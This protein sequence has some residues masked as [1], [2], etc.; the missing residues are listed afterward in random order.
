MRICRGR[1]VSLALGT[2][3]LFALVTPARFAQAAATVT[4]A[5][6]G[7]A[8]SADTVGGVF[9]S[10]TGPV[11]SEGTTADIGTG[12]IILNAP[13]GFEFD[14]AVPAVTV[15]VTRIGGTGNNNRNINNVASGTGLPVT[16]I[17]ASQIT[18]TVT[19]ATS[20]GVTNSL[21][22]QNV[23]V[24]PT[25]GTP[26]ASGNILK[27]GTS[28]IVG[29]TGSTNFGTLTEVAG[30]GDGGEE[31]DG[32][33]LRPRDI[34]PSEIEVSILPDRCTTDRKVRLLLHAHDTAE[35]K[36]GNLPDVSDG[37][38]Q[39]FVPGTDNTQVFDWILSEGD[40]EKTVSIVFKGPFFDLVSPVHTVTIKLD[41]EFLCQTPQEHAHVLDLEGRLHAVTTNPE[42]RSDFAHATVEPYIVKADGLARGW[43]DLYVR[44]TSTGPGV[45]RYAFEDGDDF[46]YDDATVRT[47]RV[48]TTVIAHVESVAGSGISE[49]RLRVDAADLGS[50][51]EQTFWRADLDA[52]STT[53]VK[54]VALEKY[55]ELCETDAVPHPHPGD[56]FQ[57]PASGL[58]Y[59]GFDRRRHVFPN[60]DVFRSWFPEGTEIMKIATYQLADIPLGDNVTLRPGTIVRVLGEVAIFVVDI[61][62]LLREVI[63]E[64]FR[65]IFQTQPLSELVRN[66]DPALV[67]NY[68]F[69]PPVLSET[70]RIGITERG[71]LP[72]INDL[73]PAPVEEE[74]AAAAY[75]YPVSILDGRVEFEGDPYPAGDVR[76]RFRILDR[77]GQALRSS[78][79]RLLEGGV[80]HLIMIH[81]HLTNLIHVHPA[82][83]DG[84]W[85][86]DVAFAEPG[87][88]FVYVDIDPAEGVP[89]I[90]RAS[91]TVGE[92]PQ[93]LLTL[94]EPNQ[95]YF[96]NPYRLELLTREPIAGTELVLEFELTKDGEP[97][98]GSDQGL[99]F[100]SYGHLTG[101]EQGNQNVYLHAHPAGAPQNGKVI[102][103]T[104]FPYPG[105]Y[106]LFPQLSVGGKV[107][108]FPITI[109]VAA[110]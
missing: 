105:R 59:R 22:W 4:P 82:E 101:F 26:L 20:N 9:T 89:A 12:T 62:R 40:G 106:S 48:G 108:V 56:V 46:A 95:Y 13:S 29:V 74:P 6:G 96:D 64:T 78:D 73:W 16:S 65:A 19:D 61:G 25:A 27:T 84:W 57:S 86:T 93:R 79:L 90:L 53:T 71:V 44:A 75:P 30:A 72:S 92:D 85:T 5:T 109:D 47:E 55:R 49:I 88:Y 7:E 11:I 38:W 52:G 50:I 18:F 107:R 21:T 32:R 14:T 45:M 94:P 104:R 83:E 42:C 8:I 97:V 3:L 2:A 1:R 31:G 51:D 91:L 87:V 34:I 17:T 80:I 98:P 102:F 69:G 68:A 99:V 33:A 15:L 39:P 24:R 41:Q 76:V 100:G 67:V 23:R 43:R 81:D 66:L 28:S 60:E 58:Y 37:A 77:E 36:I 110:P 70:E 63:A 10:L 103:M 35:V 54:T